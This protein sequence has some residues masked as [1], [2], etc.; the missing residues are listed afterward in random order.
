MSAKTIS[1]GCQCGAV[2][3]SI[4][5]LD[6]PSIC[7]CRMCQKAFGG[8]YGPL[9]TAHGLVWTRGAPKHF[10]SSNM[11]KRGFCA[12]CGTPLTYDYGDLPEIA[13]GAL[14]NPELAAP[15]VQVNPVD[16]LSFVDGLSLL[17]F[18]EFGPDDPEVDF[19]AAFISHQHPDKDTKHWVA[20]KAP[21]GE[22][23]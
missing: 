13:I 6:N 21:V 18:R 15:T 16:K 5:R 12:D 7:H 4:D 2:R 10:H 8:F 22:N 20:H 1:G 17:P 19:M 14:D 11:V 3:F 9:V 23:T